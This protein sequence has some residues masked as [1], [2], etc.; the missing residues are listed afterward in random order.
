MSQTYKNT[1]TLR[2]RFSPRPGKSYLWDSNGRQADFDF[3]ATW[4]RH[5][6]HRHLIVLIRPPTVRGKLLLKQ[7][8]YLICINGI[9]VCPDSL[10]RQIRR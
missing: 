10:H 7:Y 3:A 2:Q 1:G 6:L 8:K 4:K 9:G 5:A